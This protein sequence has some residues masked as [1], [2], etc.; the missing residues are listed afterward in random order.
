MSLSRHEAFCVA[1]L[2]LFLPLVLCGRHS[3]GGTG[4]GNSTPRP[5]ASTYRAGVVQGFFI[6]A[7]TTQAAAV[8]YFVRTAALDGVE[9]LVFAESALGSDTAMSHRASCEPL[10]NELGVNLCNDHNDNTSTPV[11]SQMSCY[12]ARYGLVLVFAMCDVQDDGQQ[13]GAPPSHYNTQVAVGPD[14]R[15]LAK[16]H[17]VRYSC[18]GLLLTLLALIRQALATTVILRLH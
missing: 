5:S 7:T 11:A 14:G 13:P 16:Y 2:A 1:L 6:N 9:I 17:K 10:P 4:V 3:V 18:G 8:E 12:A 15:L